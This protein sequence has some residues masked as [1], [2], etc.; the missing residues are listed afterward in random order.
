MSPSGACRRID[1]LPD[2]PRAIVAGARRAVLATTDDSARPHAVPVCFALR[3]DEL[4]TAIDHKPKRGT[5]LAR[6]ANIE[7]NH[8]VT[9]LVDRWDEDWTRLGWVMVRGEAR[10]DV[11]GSADAQL[12]ARY[13]QYRERPP[14]G[15]V[16]VVS[17]ERITWWTF[18]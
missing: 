7:S 16:I 5:R 15:D 4:V 3:G 17:P 2:A 8:A 12:Q 13:P 14:R 6:V 11:P 18:A 9:L 1:E 10:L